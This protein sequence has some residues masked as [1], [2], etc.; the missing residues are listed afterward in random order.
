MSMEADP[1]KL[2][3]ALSRRLQ[4]DPKFMAHVLAAYSEQEGISEDE[5]SRELDAVPELLIRLA[6][7]KRP[8]ADS[9]DFAEQVQRLSDYTLIDEDLL[10][11]VIRQVDSLAALAE[12]PGTAEPEVGTETPGNLGL[13]VLAAARDREGHVDAAED[14]EESRGEEEEQ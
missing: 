11:H 14:V 8:D 6:L 1:T 12:Y 5:L 7:C 2:L 3:L 9:E 10:T 4:G 13:G